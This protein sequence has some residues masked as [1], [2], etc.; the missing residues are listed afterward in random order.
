M[1][2]EE[3][4][5]SDL[6]QKEEEILSF[7]KENNIFQK[8][9]DKDAPQGEFVFYEGPPT[10]NG[11]PGIHHLEARAFKDIIPRYKTM[12]GFRVQRKAGWDTHGLPVELEVEKKLGLKS[13]KEI[14]VYGIEKFN[15][16]CK[17][18]VWTYVDEWRDFTNRIGY[19][20]DMDR[21]Y[22]TYKSDYIESVWNILAEVQKKD[23]LYKDY[24]VLPWCPRCGT[25]LSSH[26]LAQGYQDDTD[27]SVTAKFKVVGQDN[28]YILAWT[29]TPWTLP[30]NVALAV[31]K[32]ID[33]VELK[34]KN[35]DAQE[36]RVILAKARL[37]LIEGEYQIIREMKGSE[38][39][40]FEYEPL[41][42]YLKESVPEK[43]KDQLRNAYKVY[44]ADFVTTEDGT[45][46]VHTAVMYGQEDFELG[47]KENLPKFHLVDDSGHFTKDTGE[48][49]GRFVKDEEVAVDIIK[50]LAHRGLLFKKEKFKHSYPHCWRCKTALI[51]YARDSWYIRMSSLRSEL[52]AENEKINWEPAYIRDG[53]FGEWLRE[54]K[55]WAISR[56]RY[57]GTPLPIWITEDKT[58]MIGVDSV[59]TLKQYSKKSGN[60]Y[61]GF[62]HGWAEGNEERKVNGDP[63]RIIQVLPKG[64]EEVIASAQQLKNAGITKIFCSEFAR[65]QRTVEIIKETTGL[66]LE[67]VVDSRINEIRFGDFEE[68]D[69]D[70][71]RKTF[72]ERM[73]LTK[74]PVGGE[75]LNDVRKRV[76]EFLY[77][78][79][80][81]Y[82]NEVILIVSHGDP[83]WLMDT[84]AHGYGDDD[85]FAIAGQRYVQTG[86][87]QELPF[88]ALPHNQQYELDLHRPY[89]DEIVLE[90]DGKEFRRVKEVLDVWFDSG[91]MPFAQQ[92]YLSSDTQKVRF[93]ADYISEAIDQTRGWFYTLHAIGIL[94]GRGHAYNNVICLG[95]LLDKDGK[96]MSKS[97]GNVINPWEM[98]NQFGVD[99][100]RFWMYTRNQPGESKDFDPKTVDEVVKK[101]FN[102]VLNVM[103]FY[104]PYVHE[105]VVLSNVSTHVLDQWI[106]T[107]LD[108]VVFRMTAYLDDFKILEAARLIRDFIGD[109]SQWYLRR[110]RDRFKSDNEGDRQMAINTLGF[111]LERLSIVIAPFMPFLAEDLYQKLRTSTSQESVHL[112]LWPETPIKSAGQILTLSSMDSVRKLVTLGLEARAKL[113]IKVRQPLALL[114][115]KD[116]TL[117]GFDPYLQVLMDEVNVKSIAFNESLDSEVV[118]DGDISEELKREGEARELVRAIQDMRKEKS[119]SPLD[120][121][122]IHL[123]VT[124]WGKLVITEW[125]GD[126]KK[127]CSIDEIILLD[128]PD[129]TSEWFQVS[130]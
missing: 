114:T 115:I 76:G 59:E 55:D 63:K 47:T 87:F 116:S 8:S 42:P 130:F 2:T 32:D 21:P 17:K 96:K 11:R 35:K 79:E 41:Y 33:Y 5:K 118:L 112:E 39:A 85:M 14:E 88:A 102:L 99:P 38:I 101:V 122:T 73:R 80:S 30:G 126:I 124:S 9:I 15:D 3:T 90:K 125:E 56:E 50:D 26:E 53:R 119:L 52:L 18:S 23:L 67:V 65:T 74:A 123:S 34:I 20:I 28:M 128:L 83:L 43:Q 127:T 62:R 78:L 49:A 60:R 27:L 109:L 113:G 91:A 54:I 37:S 58:E 29:T 61:I 22:V 120:R 93:P 36:E 10:A 48:F 103:K 92:H 45:G 95:H 94:T 12:R 66:D 1:N 16:E 44:A 4:K 117:Q 107:L 71:Y 121:I 7:W 77:E 81:T 69:V 108:D 86:H 40:G 25:A 100:L 89:I 13:K 75:T 24:K 31:G 97:V 19:W 104:E 110:S 82:K 106:L 129:N 6:A 98:I 111:V 72:P 105:R 84:V 57:W 68:S 64:E 46:I 51:Y 70:E